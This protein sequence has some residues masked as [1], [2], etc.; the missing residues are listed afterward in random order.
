MGIEICLGPWYLRLWP[1][2]F[3][4]L[5][6]DLFGSLLVIILTGG[7]SLCTLSPL[8]NS[9]VLCQISYW[10][11]L[12]MVLRLKPV[13]PWRNRG[14]SVCA[15]TWSCCSAHACINVSSCNPLWGYVNVLSWHNL[16][17]PCEIH[18][19]CQFDNGITIKD[20]WCRSETESLL[21]MRT[22][23]CATRRM[24]VSRSLVMIHYGITLMC[25]L[26]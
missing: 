1:C 9:F 3:I 11:C 12:V 20:L 7:V 25:Y 13:V 26:P 15:H 4:S 18:Y 17:L 21:W 2:M 8:P 14:P 10:L 16:F 19:W 22:Q 5:G 23:D 24:L 6:H